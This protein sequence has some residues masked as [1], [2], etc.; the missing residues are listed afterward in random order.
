M[1]R[2][3]LLSA[4]LAA[5]VFVSSLAAAAPDG[6]ATRTSNHS[7]SITVAR[8]AEA[9]RAAGWV[10]FAEIDHA[11][12]AQ[13]VHMALPPRTVVLFGNP[14]AGTPAMRAHPTLAID[15]PMRVLVWADEQGHTFVTRNIGEDIATRVFARHGIVIPPEAR[16][17]MDSTIEGMVRKAVE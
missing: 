17:G 10:V 1:I 13:A 7:V 4:L 9:V 8:F 5:A 2:R 14:T 12:A 15:L 16:R 6:L 3:I 11:A